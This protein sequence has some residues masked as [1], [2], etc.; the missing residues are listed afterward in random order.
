[1]MS[2]SEQFNEES[3]AQESSGTEYVLDESS[4]FTEVEVDD[5]RLV[6]SGDPVTLTQDQYD[7]ASAAEGVKLVE[8]AQATDENEE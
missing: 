1:M 3:T 7:R 2:E 5:K 4:E 6:R 8:S